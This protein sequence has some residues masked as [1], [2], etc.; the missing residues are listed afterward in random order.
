M[1][2]R[3]ALA[4]AVAAL[5][6]GAPARAQPAWPERTVTITVCFPPGGSNDVA[7]RLI[8]TPLSEALGRPVVVENRPGAGGNIGIGAVARAQPD[9]HTLLVC[10]SAFVVNPSLYAR[11]PYDPVRDFAPVTTLGASPNVFA[12]RSQSPFRSLI[13]VLDAARANPDRLNYASS[14]VGTT[15]HL[16][17]EL[18]K[19]RA[20]AGLQ[21]IVF[22]GAGPATQ[23]AL[24]GTVEL[25]VAN[26]GS[27]EGQLRSGQ[28]RPIAV[29]APA[30]TAD[31]PDVP[32]LAELGFPGLDSDTFVGLWAPAATPAPVLAKLADAVAGVLR[33]PEVAERFRTAGIPVVSDGPQ[34]LR[35]R[36]AR[37][38]PLWHDVIRQ[39]KITPE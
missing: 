34:G 15:P 5:L 16:T 8:A 38:V 19:L 12:V 6:F 30:R 7:A 39:A 4:A 24:A 17:G 27:V 20:G 32:T 18:L 29:T 3:G 31:M 14:G 35:A 33:R 21:H 37:E 36:V 13:E 25:L 11:V 9:G 26:Q 22:A 10:S 28:L 23:A 1:R 2:R